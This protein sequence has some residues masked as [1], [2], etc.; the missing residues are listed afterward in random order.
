MPVCFDENDPRKKMPPMPLKLNP[1]V[2]IICGVIGIVG[3]TVNAVTKKKD[4]KR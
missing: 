1:L 2:S 4:N 3:F